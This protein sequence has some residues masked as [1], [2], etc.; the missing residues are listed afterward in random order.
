VAPIHAATKTDFFVKVIDVQIT[1]ERDSNGAVTRLVLH[2]P[3]DTHPGEI[4][5]WALLFPN[6][7]ARA[8][9]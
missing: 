3:R 7:S 1:S 4:R 9:A 6:A 8:G 2:P 5:L